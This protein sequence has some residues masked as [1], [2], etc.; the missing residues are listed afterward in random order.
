MLERARTL[1]RDA[2]SARERRGEQ[3]TP[4]TPPA[5]AL[6]VLD[7]LIPEVRDG[8]RGSS[9][10]RLGLSRGADD[11]DW[12]PNEQPLIDL[13]LLI[14]RYWQEHVWDPATAPSPPPTSLKIRH[15]D[16]G[17]PNSSARS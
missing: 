15:I 1:A 17:S 7:E 14:D 5:V 6:R 16:P 8:T 10:R 11:F 3:L 2:V 9:S 13:F 4:R 12:L